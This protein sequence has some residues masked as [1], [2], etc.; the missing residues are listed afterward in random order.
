M[1]PASPDATGPILPQKRDFPTTA[2]DQLQRVS[3][4]GPGRII[5]VRIALRSGAVKEGGF[6]RGRVESLYLAGVF[7]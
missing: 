2:G 4:W 5:P 6:I 7:Q 1:V 3:H